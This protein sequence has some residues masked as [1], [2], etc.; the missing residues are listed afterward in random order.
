MLTEKETAYIESQ[1]LA[2]IATVTASGQP[3]VSPVDFDFDGQ[4]FYIG[5]GQ[6]QNS[7]KFINVRN[8]N[9]KVAIA[10]D[11]FNPD[12]P[13]DIRGF[14]LHGTADIVERDKGCA[15]SGSYLRIKPDVTWSW[16]VQAPVFQDGRFIVN[17]TRWD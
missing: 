5:D 2:R 14:K 6:N 3:D 1:R 16:G 13:G 10:I 12:D 9:N 4:Y 8:G 7:R 15:G 17:K 11:D